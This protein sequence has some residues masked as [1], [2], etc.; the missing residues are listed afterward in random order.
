[1]AK[2]ALVD[3]DCRLAFA[4]HSKRSLHA[5]D[6]AADDQHIRLMRMDS[7]LLGLDRLSLLSRLFLSLCVRARTEQRAA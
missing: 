6:T 1:M 3:D 2:H 5:R 7:T 4:H